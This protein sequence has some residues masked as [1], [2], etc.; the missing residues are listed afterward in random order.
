MCL[1]VERGSL[2]LKIPEEARQVSPAAISTHY[3]YDDLWLI[4]FGNSGAVVVDRERETLMVFCPRHRFRKILLSLESLFYPMFELMRRH[5]VYPIHSGAV[6]LEGKGVVIAGN[7]GAG[8]STLI[9]HLVRSGF[10]F[11]SDDRCLMRRNCGRYEVVGVHGFARVYPQ[12]V[13]DA[14]ELHSV[15]KHFKEEH[16]KKEYDIGQIYP[17]R[18]AESAPVEMILLPQWKGNGTTR[19]KPISP[20][21]AA[22][23]LLPLSV[24]TLFPDTARTQFQFIG[25]LVER[26]AVYR[27]E[28]GEDRWR[29]PHMLKELM[30]EA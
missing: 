28:L 14:P 26:V 25:E 6:S 18:V 12:N 7:S 24:E 20:M 27:M 10:N 2:P 16:C 11:L 1:L 23:Q 15:S 21:D 13:C 29:W 9:I 4:D 5:G 30:G 8:K 22:I 19:I 17:D 3:L